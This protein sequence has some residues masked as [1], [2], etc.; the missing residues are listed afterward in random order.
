MNKIRSTL[1][2][3]FLASCSTTSQIPTITSTNL[4]TH[5]LVPTETAIPPTS[6]FTPT[7][8]PTI[9]LTP[10]PTWTPLPTLADQNSFLDFISFTENGIC[11][12][13]CFAGIT[14]GETTWDEAIFALRPME[15]V[16][17]LDISPNQESNYGQVNIISWYL[18]GGEYEVEGEFLTGSSVNLIWMDIQSFSIPTENIPSRSLPLPKPF[19]LQS[20]LKAYGIPSMVFIY[21]FVHDQS[22]S[23]PF[24]ILLVYPEN[25]FYIEYHRH[26]KL[27]GNSVVACDSDYY[28][29]LLVVDN[30]DKLISVDAISNTP[31]AKDFDFNNWKPVEQALNISPEK[32]HEIYSA[33]SPGCMISPKSIWLP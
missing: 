22:S 1:L 8:T 13:P 20:V 32:F 28:T 12:F 26:A 29:D 23:P 6:T 16:A 30:K 25:Q 21:T 3:I 7:L 17:K 5:T 11:K 2:F 18:Y 4:P 10:L 15:A 31:K 19:N 9:T 14:Q 33:S 24:K 27:S